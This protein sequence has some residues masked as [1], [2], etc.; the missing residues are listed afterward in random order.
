MNASQVYLL[1][2]IRGN[3]D[4]HR[5]NGKH[6]D[7]GIYFWGFNLREDG[8]MPE[9]KEDIL[10][11][12]IGKSDGN[13]TERIMQEATQLLFGGFGTIINHKHLKKNNFKARLINHQDSV[14]AQ[15]LNDIVLYKS[16]GLHVLYDFVSMNETKLSN[17]IAWMRENLLFSWINTTKEFDNSLLEGEFH[18]IVRTNIFGIGQMKKLTPKIKIENTR[19][20]NQINW[21]NCK[22]LKEWFEEVNNNIPDEIIGNNEIFIHENKGL[23]GKCGLDSC[24]NQI[25]E[26]QPCYSY[27]IGTNQKRNNNIY[28]NKRHLRKH[29]K[30]T[31]P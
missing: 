15:K 29:Y 12:Y 28:C 27:S 10:I 7:K 17:T 9:K 5:K 31:S 13:I 3:F 14:E 26:I 20:F 25:N 2:E 21:D 4:F 8:K 1:K 23:K 19:Y 11:Y 6:N 30:K 18:K 24:K 16:Y 22:F